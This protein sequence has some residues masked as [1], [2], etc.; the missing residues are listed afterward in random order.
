MLTCTVAALIGD[1]TTAVSRKER[2]NRSKRDDASKHEKPK[3]VAD[4]PPQKMETPNCSPS[5]GSSETKKK[6]CIAIFRFLCLTV[7]VRPEALRFRVVHAFVC[8]SQIL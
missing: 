8:A 7:L 1:W 3:T 4:V 6:V 5:P 2:K